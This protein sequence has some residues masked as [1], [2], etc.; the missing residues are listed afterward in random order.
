MRAGGCT[1]DGNVCLEVGR[2]LSLSVTR[3]AALT[4]GSGVVLLRQRVRVSPAH[5][6]AKNP[7]G[8]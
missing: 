3:A 1:G 6:S 2:F 5:R 7:G 8:C 4:R